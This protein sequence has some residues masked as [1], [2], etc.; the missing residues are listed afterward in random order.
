MTH[1]NL[2]NWAVT[3]L[4]LIFSTGLSA[5]MHVDALGNVGIG[6]AT[7]ADPLH[8]QANEAGFPGLFLLEN[9]G[10]D[11]AG[12]R[13]TTT[14]GSID[15]NKAGGN[16]FRLNIVDGDT[17]EMELN[18]AGDL[19]IKGEIITAGSCSAGCDRVFSP[20]YDLPTIEEHAKAMWS[21]SYLPAVG[22]TKEGEPLNLSVK[23]E[24]ILNELEKAHIYV[25][26]LHVRNIALEQRVQELEKQNQ[27]IEELVMLMVKNQAEQ[28]AAN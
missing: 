13:F 2:I 11:F 9:L 22:A 7:P 17:W 4:V 25:E 8:V 16:T 20:D 15:F 21:N 3:V 5:Q 28:V 14:G 24:R 10:S 12:F 27:R 26:Q 6:T 23:T 19:T 18:P 1:R